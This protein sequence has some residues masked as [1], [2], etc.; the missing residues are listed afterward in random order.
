LKEVYVYNNKLAS[1]PKLSLSTLEIL[2]CDQEVAANINFQAADNLKQLVI[3]NAKPKRVALLNL[4]ER[5][6]AYYL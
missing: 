3:Y 4:S 5:I 2:H 1:I 6:K